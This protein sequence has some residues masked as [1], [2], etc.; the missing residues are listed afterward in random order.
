MKHSLQLR[1]SQHLAMTPRLQQAIRLLQLSTM[2]LHTEVQDAL[3]SNLMLELDEDDF[4]GAGSEPEIAP[5]DIPRE[6][7]VDSVWEDIYDSSPV[8]GAASNGEFNGTDLVAHHAQ[9]ESL[10]DR[11]GWQISLIRLEDTDRVIAAALID[12]VD[13]D[14]YLTLTLEDIRHSLDPQREELTLERIEAVLSRAPEPRSARRRGTQ[15]EGMPRDS[16]AAA[17]PGHGLARCSA[18]RGDRA[19]ARAGSE[20]LRSAH[21]GARTREARGPMRRRPDPLSVPPPRRHGRARCPGVRDSRHLRAQGERRLEGRAEFGYVSQ[22]AHQFPVREP[23]PT[24]RRQRGQPYAEEPLAGGALVHQEPSEPRRDAAEDGDV[25][26]RTP[27]GV[28]R[29]RRKNP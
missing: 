17:P 27:A 21:D 6:L 9:T 8:G 18:R 29:A 28:S 23:H 14:G 5:A 12:A 2:E 13:E 15:P 26:R 4:T 24:R 19:S 10:K 7:P 11:L 1:L 25:H 22:T 16:V 20:E 3:D